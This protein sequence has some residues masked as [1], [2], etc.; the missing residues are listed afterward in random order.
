MCICH[1]RG[2][3]FSGEIIV[4]VLD[5]TRPSATT[6]NLNIFQVILLHDIAWY[7]PDVLLL[8]LLLFLLIFVLFCFF[9]SSFATA[10]FSR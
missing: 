4:V 9:F 2:L 5:D 8:L 6:L 7:T 1:A 3:T 10:R